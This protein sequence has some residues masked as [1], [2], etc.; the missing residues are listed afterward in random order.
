MNKNELIQLLH[1]PAQTDKRHLSALEQWKEKYP[2]FAPVHMLYLK[3]LSKSAEPTFHEYLSKAAA[4]VPNRKILFELV[5]GNPRQQP[6]LGTP[7]A[8]KQTSA[9]ASAK[10][11][12][13]GSI[14]ESIA[15]TLEL[16]LET[17]SS[18]NG[19]NLQYAPS[20]NIEKEYGPNIITDSDEKP[21]EISF[22][23]SITP[24]QSAKSKTDYIELLEDKN[25][26]KDNKIGG[27]FELIDQ[28]IKTKPTIERQ[29]DEENEDAT[30]EPVK[31]ISETSVKE[32]E[33]FMTDTLAK[34]YLKQ[35]K[36]EKAKT[37][38]EKLSLKYP[39]KSAYFAGQI[40]EIQEYINKSNT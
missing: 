9:P 35:K 38:Y 36:Y 32:H 10:L 26:K 33:G 23:Q 25:P 31:D 37:V 30:N 5:Y 19:P 8:P 28:F 16:Q 4:F 14:K 20:I 39:E 40:K 1:N 22:R 12:N 13:T 11:K 34:I 29:L 17:A 18:D 21:F 2:Y 27:S 6:L 24:K 15:D 3:A 7:E